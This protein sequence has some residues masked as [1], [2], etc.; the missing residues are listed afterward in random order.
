[1]IRRVGSGSLYEPIVGYCR[2]VRYGDVIAVSGTAPIMDDGGPPPL[3]AFLQARRCL[4][5]IDKAL[6]DLCEAQ[7]KPVVVRTRVYLLKAEDWTEVGR[8][9][10]DRFR[11][12][13][14]ACTF[15]AVKGLLDP[16]W[17][18]EIEADAVVV[19]SL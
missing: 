11:H 8:A 13:P 14:P 19:G 7:E 2:A 16:M 18:V 4:D 10:G 5:I 3:D 15:V 12:E 1:V 9:H 6:F 17:L